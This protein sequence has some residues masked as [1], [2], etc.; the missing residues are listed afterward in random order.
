VL[1]VQSDAFNRSRI[2]TVVALT[3]TSNLELARAPGNVAL[4][5]RATGLP[6]RSVANVSQV[7]TI[8][9]SLLTERVRKLPDGDLA[10]VEA[11][12]RLVLDL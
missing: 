11:G 8:D 6:R 5:R 4:N 3:L 2:N 10:E 7:V 12:L 1:I 9:R